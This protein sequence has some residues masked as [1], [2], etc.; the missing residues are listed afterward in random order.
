MKLFG[1][2]Q[3]GHGFVNR[4]FL[5]GPYLPI[6]GIGVLVLYFV[7]RKLIKKDIKIW[8][9]PVTPVIV[10]IAIMVIV[11]FIEY[12]GSLFLEKCFGM[13]LWNYSYDKFNLNGRISLRNSA[14]LSAGAMVML[15]LVWPLLE[16]LYGKISEKVAKITAIIICLVMGC[17][18]IITL[19]GL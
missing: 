11:S 8:K 6:Y 5:H 2:R 18:L 1:K 19:I 4:G 12:M 3:F 15:Y 14:C 10:F 7:L 17:D 9:I 16:K 13:E